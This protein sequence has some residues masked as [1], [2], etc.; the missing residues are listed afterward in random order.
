MTLR[1]MKIS[2]LPHVIAPRNVA[3]VWAGRITTAVVIILLALTFVKMPIARHGKGET[4]YRTT[5][6]L[7]GDFQEK[8]VAQ[9]LMTPT[10]MDFAPDGRLFV[11]EKSGKLLVIQNGQLLPTP[12]FSFA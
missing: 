8:L 6:Q 7:T 10:A 3:G 11:A 1:G 12:F 4:R 5:T 2:T 9:G